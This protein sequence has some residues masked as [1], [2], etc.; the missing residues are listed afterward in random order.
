MLQG[1]KSA[2][3]WNVLARWNQELIAKPAM[4]TP[5]EALG[6]NHGVKRQRRP[7]VRLGDIGDPPAAIISESYFKRKKLSASSAHFQPQTAHV[8]QG[9]NVSNNDGNVVLDSSAARGKAS[10]VSKTRPSVHVS[11]GHFHEK[12]SCNGGDNGHEHPMPLDPSFSRNVT[13]TEMQ[14]EL[15]TSSSGGPARRDPQNFVKISSRKVRNGKRRRGGPRILAPFEILTKAVPSIIEID[16]EDNE[17]ASGTDDTTDPQFDEAYNADTPEG[18]RDCDLE[19][20]E[21]SEDVKGINVSQKVRLPDTGNLARTPLEFQQ[22]NR[23]LRIA[24]KYALQPEEER[25]DMSEDRGCSTNN[26]VGT[27]GNKEATP[28]PSSD[29]EVKP[30]MEANAESL[31]EGK[32][33]LALEGN[34]N[35]ENEEPTNEKAELQFERNQP[36]VRQYSSLVNGVRG[37][38]Q[39]LGLGKYAQLFETHEV[40]TEVLPLLT[41]DDLKD[42]G[43]MAVGTRR[44]MLFAIQQLGKGLMGRSDSF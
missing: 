29:A 16:D 18:F 41:L 9:D 2:A 28:E 30:F 44:K 14:T 4:T 19:V 43:V 24:G 31:R 26:L 6:V 15:H 38:L 37:W 12:N 22:E 33:R 42:M 11:N 40:D 3:M 10:K 39:G 27:V 35:F 17:K 8:K 13:A 20:S 1:S 34:G 5:S 32:A 7:S 36:L 25:V 21:Y 23:C